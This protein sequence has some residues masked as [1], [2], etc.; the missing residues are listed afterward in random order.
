MATDT[1]VVVIGGNGYIGSRLTQHLHS[2]GRRVTA[3]DSFIRPDAVRDAPYQ[4]V[5]SAY[6]DLDSEFL[7]QFDDC[8]WLA[9]HASVSQ[10]KNDPKGALWNNFFDLIEFRERFEGRLIYA[11]SGSVYSRAKPEECTEES[12]LANPSNMYDFTKTAFDLYL[13]SQEIDAICLRF[14]TVNGPSA[15]FRNELMLNKMVSDGL[16][17]GTVTVRNARVWRPILF[18]DDLIRGLVAILDSDCRSGTFNLCSV[19]LTVREYANAVAHLTG[20]DIDILE[21]TPTYNFIM[22]SHHVFTEILRYLRLR[23]HQQSVSDHPDAHR[24]LQTTGRRKSRVNQTVTIPVSGSGTRTSPEN[25]LL[26]S[27]LSMESR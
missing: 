27:R 8:V 18:M 2:L 24:I 4:I 26:A 20:A 7:S 9:G 19:N 1:S 3:V 13:A 15:R 12:H 11:S 25:P 10:S 17:L 14:G 6:Q 23:I 5:E 16:R 21:D 22:S